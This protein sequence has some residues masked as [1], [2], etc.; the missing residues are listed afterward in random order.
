MLLP[1]SGRYIAISPSSLRQHAASHPF[2]GCQHHRP[3]AVCA[4]QCVHRT[5]IQD[6]NNKIIIRNL[7][8]PLSPELPRYLGRYIMQMPPNLMP[9]LLRRCS[10]MQNDLNPLNEPTMVCISIGGARKPLPSVYRP[11]V[12]CPYISWKVVV[13]PQPVLGLE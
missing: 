9:P 8:H 3:L 1:C 7:V 2:P 10:V 11:G 6:S 13:R 4:N 12:L 5:I